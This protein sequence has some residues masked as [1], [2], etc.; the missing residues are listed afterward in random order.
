VA[1]IV[2]AIARSADTAHIATALADPHPIAASTLAAN[3][4]LAIITPAPSSLT[5]RWLRHASGLIAHL[6]D[7][8]TIIPGCLSTP[9]AS[10]D[11]ADRSLRLRA[12]ILTDTFTRIDG[13]DQWSIRLPALN[14]PT[15]TPQPPHDPQSPSPP[16]PTGTAYLHRL[17]QH[18]SA[19]SAG[20]RAAQ[21][22]LTTTLAPLAALARSHRAEAPTPLVNHPRVHL[23]IPR[24]LRDQ[25]RLTC[26][27]LNSGTLSGPF[28][29]FDF[30]NTQTP[31][32]ILE[33]AA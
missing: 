18:L 10:E 22:A 24:T 21:L 4:L 16:A 11:E 28:A 27:A 15:S 23:L 30:T 5:P 7:H 8:A 32:A 19:E 3:N 6:H 14:T 2:L 25:L 33:P 26:A 12:H 9:L 17:R 13:C 1:L 20:L 29:P 31:A